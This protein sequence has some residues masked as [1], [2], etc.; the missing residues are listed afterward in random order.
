MALVS[1]LKETTSSTLKIGA[2]TLTVPADA[3]VSN[4][5]TGDNAT[6]SQYS[7]LVTNATHTGDVTGAT[8]LT[9]ANKV[10]MTATSPITVSGT[11]TV[12]AGSAV[13]F[14]ISAATAS[15]N[16]Y[17]TSAQI[18][19]L[20]GIAAGATAV[21]VEDSAVDGH[22]TQAISSNALFD[23]NA[24]AATASV[25]GHATATQITKLDGI[26]SSA[27]A[28]AKASAAE[29]LTGTDDTKFV[30]PLG[31]TPI[32]P[33][34]NIIINGAMDIWQ[35]GTSFTSGAIYTA[36][37]WKV[38]NAAGQAVAISTNVPTG[39]TSSVQI[40]NTSGYEYISQYIEG[41]NGAKLV[42]KTVTF[43]AYIKNVSG[44][45]T[46]YMQIGT[47]DA[48]DT[49]STATAAVST[50]KTVTGSW[51][52]YSTSVVIPAAGVNGIFVRMYTGYNEAAVQLVTGCQL[53]LGA[54]ATPF[55]F[56]SFAQ[57][58]TLCQRYYEKSYNLADAPASNTSSGMIG[59]IAYATSAC[60]LLPW[61]I[62]KRTAPTVVLYSKLGT[63][64]KVSLPDFA[65]DVG[66]SVTAAITGENSYGFMTDSGSGFTTGTGC[67]YHYTASAEL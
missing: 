35:R 55:E 3:S 22:T 18:T 64:A 43:S 16:G 29:V 45:T 6:N 24:I 46:I 37:R 59:T 27:T 51:V 57:E 66:T 42:G 26:A 12:I 54:V 50:L 58:L 62:S 39:F 4:T 13:A 49:F 20:D 10:T 9:I 14:A 65:T 17:A 67:V 19:K 38:S 56:R 23:H 7:G 33:N 48:L 44:G 53:E 11:P 30:T 40:T 47:A 63:A 5:N 15:V 25:Q 2:G 34:R 36:D 31:I 60:F 61:K 32:L 1:D 52:R 28:N 8:A 21:V 41:V